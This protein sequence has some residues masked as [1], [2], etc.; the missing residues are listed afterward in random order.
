MEWHSAD[1]RS[2]E[3]IEQACQEDLHDLKFMRFRNATIAGQKVMILRMGMAGSLAYEVHGLSENC[4]DVYNAIYEAGKPFGIRRLGWQAYC[5]CNHTENGFPQGFIHFSYP[6]HLDKDY[7]QWMGGLEGP[8][9]VFRGSLPAENEMLRYVTPYDASWGSRVKFDHDFVGRAALEKIAQN[10][11]KTMVTLEWNA[12]D[13][14]DVYASLFREETYDT[15][16]LP[17]YETTE[18]ADPLYMDSVENTD[19]KLIGVSSGRI[20]TYYYKNMISLCSIDK[21]Y[22][23]NGTEVKIVWGEP[24]HPQKII[25]AKVARLP[26]ES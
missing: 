17:Y 15:L 20:Y 13:V 2:L 10:P 1:P 5:I 3:V 26:S 7:S 21:E 24:G 18:G 16:D 8:I 12:E 19:G 22:A 9:Q 11:P 25:R 14:T 23:A 6:W 4:L